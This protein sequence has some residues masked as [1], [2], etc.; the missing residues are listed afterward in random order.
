MFPSSCCSFKHQFLFSIPSFPPRPSA[1]NKPQYE[2][3]GCLT[4]GCSLPYSA[5]SPVLISPV[6]AMLLPSG[7][8]LLW[9]GDDCIL[10]LDETWL[11]S[12]TLVDLVFP[13][14][15]D[16]K[17][18]PAYTLQR[19]PQNDS[20]IVKCLT[21]CRCRWSLAASGPHECFSDWDLFANN[22]HTYI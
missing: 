15:L 17:K 22:L 20:Q 11:S 14:K 1:A 19:P 16:T 6:C 5:I 7:D 8:F 21:R 18:R 3:Q 13:Q 2:Y 10:S 9:W 12:K 4:L